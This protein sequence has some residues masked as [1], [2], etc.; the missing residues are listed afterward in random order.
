MVVYRVDPL[1]PLDL[2]PRAADEKIRVEASKRVDEI[3]KLHKH[4]MTRIE[5]SNASYQAQANK[6]KKRVVF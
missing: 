6:R 3:Q 2:V 1:S 4:V 5:K